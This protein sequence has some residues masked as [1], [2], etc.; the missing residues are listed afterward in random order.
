MPFSMPFHH[1]SRSIQQPRICTIF[2][3]LLATALLAT[4]LLA[5]N[6]TVEA[7]PDNTFSPSN[8][9]IEM[10]DTVTFVN[11]GGFHNVAASNGSF[12]CAEGC[13]G[14]GGN[15]DPSSSAWSATV[16]FNNVGTVDY[17]CEVHAGLGMAGTIVV[18]QGDPDEPGNLRFSAASQ[19]RTE[20]SGSFTVQVARV[21][22]DDGAVSVDYA[23]SDGSAQGG[24]DYTPASGTLTWPDGDDDPRSFQVPI[25]DDGA[26]EA[27]ETINVA[28]SNPTG[29]AGL[30]TPSNATLTIQ[31][32]DDATPQP[33]QISFVSSQFSAGEETGT[34]TIT[35][36][37]TGGTE[38]AVGVDFTTS[39]G[40]ALDGADYTAAMGTLNWSGGEGGTKSF[41]VPLLDDAEEENDETVNLMLS[42]PT[43]GAGLGTSTATLEIEDDD[44]TADCVADET[45]L[46]L[47]ATSRFQV[48]V[49]WR[50]FDGNTGPGKVIP[51]DPVD[52]GLFYFFGPDNAE[53]LLKVLNACTFNDHFWVFTAATTNVEYTITVTDTQEDVSN[54]Y[55]NPL[56]ERAA[57]VTDT[58]AFATCP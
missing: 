52:S 58:T 49:T 17:V 33:G 39:D 21:G 56:G 44:R 51:F 34:A 22:G 7:R 48:R 14:Q 28:L 19:S 35:V 1:A 46:C 9:T 37:R 43:G 54:T 12:R 25:L 11:A 41:D 45:T 55:S 5:A 15:G 20:G 29:G 24:V 50:D 27:S 23:T 16:T 53:I 42:N 26:D 38:G 31:D 4:P 40:S 10:G 2:W 36:Q 8:L 13:D 3:L 57:A 47:T 32:D 18:Q 6:H 30:T